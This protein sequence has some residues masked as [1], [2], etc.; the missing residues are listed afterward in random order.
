MI[1]GQRY[2]QGWIPQGVGRDAGEAAKENDEYVDL[3]HLLEDAEH[4]EGASVALAE[5]Q[6][7][8]RSCV[9]GLSPGKNI[10]LL[11]LKPNHGGT[12]VVVKVRSSSVMTIQDGRS[13][14]PLEEVGTGSC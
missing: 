9:S 7:V 11:E 8:V 4:F 10:G 12:S 13:K 5:A 1:H 14:F 6:F 3:I 2:I